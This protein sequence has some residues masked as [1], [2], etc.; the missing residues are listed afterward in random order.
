MA[1]PEMRGSRLGM[2][3]IALAT[4]DDLFVLESDH[5][6]DSRIRGQAAVEPI[7]LCN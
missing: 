2:V 3:A 4:G 1:S 6:V 5:F 7:F